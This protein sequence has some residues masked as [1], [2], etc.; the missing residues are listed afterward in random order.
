[1]KNF[2]IALQPPNPPIETVEGMIITITAPYDEKSVTIDIN[3]AFDDF[4]DDNSS[5][6]NEVRGVTLTHPTNETQ[7]LTLRLNETAKIKNYSTWNIVLP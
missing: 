6:G 2:T 7:S 1:M 4:I 5:D 3:P